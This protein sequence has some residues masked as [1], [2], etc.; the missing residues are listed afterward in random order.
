MGEAGQDGS[1]ENGRTGGMVDSDKALVVTRGRQD[2]LSLRRE[3]GGQQG[4]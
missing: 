3:P 2:P 1:S 4:E